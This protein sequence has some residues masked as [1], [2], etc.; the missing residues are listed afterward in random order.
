ML[1]QNGLHKPW[2]G[3]GG[4]GNCSHGAGGMGQ[5]KE[6]FPPILLSFQKNASCTTLRELVERSNQKMKPLG[7]AKLRRNP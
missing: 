4:G 6:I 7:V 5:G 3:G 1:L 2:G